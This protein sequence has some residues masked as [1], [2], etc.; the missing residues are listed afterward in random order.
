MCNL[1]CVLSY[2][3][4]VSNRNWKFA[5]KHIQD[6]KEEGITAAG[7]AVVAKMH[8]LRADGYAF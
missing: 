3:V 5:D 1:T 2:S 6:Y 8:T 4:T 7:T